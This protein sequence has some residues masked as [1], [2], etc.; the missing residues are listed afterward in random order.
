M[1]KVCEKN[2]QQRTFCYE[3]NILHQ[4]IQIP[5]KLRTTYIVDRVEKSQVDE[6]V[7]GC[8]IISSIY[9]YAN[10]TTVQL[11]KASIYTRRKRTFN[12]G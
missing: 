2:Q 11:V 8:L 3:E 12:T 9:L 7:K 10:Y 4:Y 1:L 6:G 5:L